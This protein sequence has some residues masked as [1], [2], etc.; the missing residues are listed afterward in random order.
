MEHEK[1]LQQDQLQESLASVQRVIRQHPEEVKYRIYLFQLLSVLGDWK[2]AL[3]QLE[4]IGKLEAE[5]LGMVQIYRAAIECELIRE[6]VFTGSQD[7]VFMGKPEAWQAL[8]LQALKL[9]LEDQNQSAQDIREQAYEQAPVSAGSLNEE[10]FAWIADADSRLG[11]MLEAF[12]EGRYMWIP[13]TNIVNLKFPEPNDLRDVVWMSAHAKWLGGGESFV[14]IPTRYPF[15][16]QQTDQIALSKRTEWEESQANTYTGHGQ[17]VLT[18][19][20][21]DY[22]LMEIR[23]L[24]FV[25][26]TQGAG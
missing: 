18:T 9:S 8:M 2:R 13:F 22:S 24:Q 14:L 12:V 1:Y 3:K 21:N 23:D 6:A 25:E 19:D 20:Q 11:P 4:V 5:A 26:T 7:P 15:S 16:Y 10:T 17:R